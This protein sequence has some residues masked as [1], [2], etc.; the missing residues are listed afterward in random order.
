[1]SVCVRDRHYLFFP[2]FAF[3]FFEI[4]FLKTRTRFFS[5]WVSDWKKSEPVKQKRSCVLSERASAT[6]KMHSKL[7]RAVS[8]HTHVCL[9]VCV[10]QWVQG[11]VF[12]FVKKFFFYYIKMFHIIYTTTMM[13]MCMWEENQRRKKNCTMSTEQA[14]A[15]P[16]WWWWYLCFMLVQV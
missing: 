11:L 14:A 3:F 8:I 4:K 9:C 2:P 6:T 15:P 16:E 12:I 5:M 10:H 7:H 13:M 1:M